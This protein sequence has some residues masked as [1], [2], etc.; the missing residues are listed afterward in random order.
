MTGDVI[1]FP[2]RPESLDWRTRKR[3]SQTRGTYSRVS[4]RPW[5]DHLCVTVV[6]IPVFF[7]WGHLLVVCQARFALLQ[8]CVALIKDIQSHPGCAEPYTCRRKCCDLWALPLQ[9]LVCKPLKW[10]LYICDNN[11]R[12]V[13]AKT[14]AVWIAVQHKMPLKRV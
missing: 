14:N 8:W 6:Y 11:G 13:V 7:L 2:P 1:G 9:A 12:T 4:G 3:R 5:T 10:H